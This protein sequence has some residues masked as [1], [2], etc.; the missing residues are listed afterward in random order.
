MSPQGPSTPFRLSVIVL[1]GGFL[2]MPGCPSAKTAF[3][4]P[5]PSKRLDAIVD[6]AA[7]NDRSS[8]R[9]L[10]DMLSSDDP[11]ERMLAI[12]TLERLT[13]QTFG[14]RHQDPEWKRLESV[15][16]WEQWLESN[17]TGQAQGGDTADDPNPGGEVATS[18]A[19]NTPGD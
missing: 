9:P 1:A 6:A 4:S 18:P 19:R 11:A 2:M 15:N 14:Y 10:V 3:D 5:A 13:N 17:Q 12:R 8:Y 7:K 16:R